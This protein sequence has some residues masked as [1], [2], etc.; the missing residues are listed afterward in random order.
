MTGEGDAPALVGVAVPLPLR[1]TFT[2]SVPDGV[3]GGIAVGGRVRVP[4]GRRIVKG[5]VVEWPAPAPEAGVAVKDVEEVLLA[6]P[7]LGA[8]LLELT[9]FVADYY[10][11][12]WG[13]AIEAALPP[14]PPALKRAQKAVTGAR[15]DAP[16]T[17]VSGPEPTPAQAAVLETL[18]PAVAARAFAPYL[19]WG[20][21]GSGKTEVYLRAAE[22]TLGA[23]RGVLYLVPE[24]GLTPL[25]VSRIEARFPGKVATL[26][27]A[28]SPR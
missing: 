14:D 1:R 2:Y 7:A 6:S 19:L 8:H 20:A 5:T 13:E 17:P 10:L 27:S 12:S 23:G 24:I 15:V 26:H 4:F 25:L 18:L 28:L 9:R 21:T 11:C 16:A 22:A 3:A